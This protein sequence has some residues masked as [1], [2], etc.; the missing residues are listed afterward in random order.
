MRRRVTLSFAI[1]LGA[2][3]LFVPQSHAQKNVS[4]GEFVDGVVSTVN[5]KVITQTELWGQGY[6]MLLQRGGE[7]AL[8]REIDEEYLQAVLQ[9]MTLQTLLADMGNQRYEL[10]A[11]EG[12]VDKN[13][14]VLMEYLGGS[15]KALVLFNRLYL[16]PDLVRGFIR[17]DNMA[18]RTLAALRK[19]EAR[20]RTVSAQDQT[21]Q[22]L[23]NLIAAGDITKQPIKL[24]K[25]YAPVRK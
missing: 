6:L 21:M 17:R 13:Y 18:S 15:E 24:P 10:I 3:T 23:D 4:K 20:D 16:S 14:K 11:D 9:F 22:L 12:N 2:L 8:G 5:Q 7:S 25:P 1:I 19:D